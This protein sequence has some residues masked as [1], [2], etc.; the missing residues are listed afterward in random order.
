MAKRTFYTYY[1]VF[2]TMNNYRGDNTNNY[3]G[4]KKHL[5]G[6][7]TRLAAAGALAHRRTINIYGETINCYGGTIYTV[8]VGTMNWY[9]R[10]IYIVIV[11][12]INCYGWA[13]YTVIMVTRNS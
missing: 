1:S 8:I 12:T 5:L 11:G 13:L 2:K 4:D 7:N 6:N 9:C 10:K 3:C